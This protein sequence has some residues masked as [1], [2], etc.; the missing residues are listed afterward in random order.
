VALT[1]VEGGLSNPLK[2]HL[3]GAVAVMPGAG[4]VLNLLK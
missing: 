2:I 3:L 4:E 1:V